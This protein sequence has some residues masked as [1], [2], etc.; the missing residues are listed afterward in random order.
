VWQERIAERREA[1]Q[2]TNSGHLVLFC[3]T[4]HGKEVVEQVL[5]VGHSCVVTEVGVGETILACP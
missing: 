3:E 5:H 2:T 1:R 4:G